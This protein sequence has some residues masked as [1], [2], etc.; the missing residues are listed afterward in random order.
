MNRGSKDCGRKDQIVMINRKTR[1]FINILYEEYVYFC[2]YVGMYD[3]MYS[4]HRKVFKNFCIFMP[5]KKIKFLSLY[6]VYFFGRICSLLNRAYLDQNIKKRRSS[7]IF[8]F[9]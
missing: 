6:V 3:D 7:K 5:S 4:I 1:L 9:L 8:L 2:M